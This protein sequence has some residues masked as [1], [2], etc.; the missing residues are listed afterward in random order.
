MNTDENSQLTHRIWRSQASA[1]AGSSSRSSSLSALMTV[2]QP[3][4]G[5]RL[6]AAA[7]AATVQQRLTVTWFL[8][9]IHVFISAKWTEWTGEISC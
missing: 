8:R 6:P 2:A 7:A 4:T 3:W 5:W 9:Y 1:N